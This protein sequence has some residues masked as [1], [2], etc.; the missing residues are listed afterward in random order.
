MLIFTT[1]KKAFRT[2]SR[3]ITE[4]NNRTARQEFSQKNN[5]KISKV[6]KQTN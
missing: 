3:V 6:Q 1:I 5:F 2:N 4:K